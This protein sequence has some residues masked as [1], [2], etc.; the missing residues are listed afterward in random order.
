M[1]NGSWQPEVQLTTTSVNKWVSVRWSFYNNPLAGENAK[2]D[3]IWTEGE[4]A[5]YEIRHAYIGN[6]SNLQPY[7]PTLTD[8]PD[9][10]WTSS[11][12]LTFKWTFADPNEDDNQGGFMVII[13]NDPS[14]G[15][16]DYTSGDVTST[17][18]EWSPGFSIPDGTWYWKVRVKDNWGLWGFY[19]GYWTV[20]I[21]TSAPIAEAGANQTVSDDEVVNFD[22]SGSSDAESGITSYSWDF[23]ASVDED[24]DGN[25]TNDAEATGVTA[26]HTYDTN[27]I[28]IVTLTVT[29]GAGVSTTDVLYVNVT[30][31]VTLSANN[32]TL[33]GWT[34]ANMTASSLGDLINSEIGATEITIAKWNATAGNWD[35][36]LWGIS[37]SEYDFTLVYGGGYFIWVDVAGTIELWVA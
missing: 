32:W 20:K 35:G 11:D 1:Y 8:P 17:V 28:Y 24:G 18:S 34:S 14:F 23:D 3:Y 29:N 19:S 27:G 5:R 10:T 7:A 30:R 37:P 6:D 12:I 2:I 9:D 16:I 26:S 25:P 31:T 4:A 15:S 33:V 21:D 22:A 13:D 36:Y